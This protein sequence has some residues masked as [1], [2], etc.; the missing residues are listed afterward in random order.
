MTADTKDGR[1]L[2]RGGD[3]KFTRSLATAERDAKA[4]RLRSQGMSY[5]RIARE[6]GLADASSARSAVERAL[7]DTVREPAD[8]LRTLMDA[9]LDQLTMVCLTILGTRHLV[10]GSGGQV[11]R[12]PATGDPL[13]DD[14][15]RLQAVDRLLKIMERRAKL[16]GV[17][18][19]AKIEMRSASELDAEIAGLLDQLADARGIASGPSAQAL[20]GQDDAQLSD[21]S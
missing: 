5:P 8:E 13:L 4:C 20:T 1:A 7:R 6:L 14:M 3:G 11:A 17:D 18:A 2:V 10:T 9:Q 15:P 16:H 19:P 21:P 12:D